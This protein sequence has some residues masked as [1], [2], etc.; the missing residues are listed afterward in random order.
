MHNLWRTNR[1]HLVRKCRAVRRAEKAGCRKRIIHRPRTLK[2]W[3]VLCF[4]TENS[5][6]QFPHACNHSGFSFHMCVWVCIWVC[7][8]FS[9]SFIRVSPILPP[10]DVDANERLFGLWCSK[11]GASKCTV[12]CL[13][14]TTCL[15]WWRWS[16]VRGARC[17]VLWLHLPGTPFHPSH[18]IHLLGACY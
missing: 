13:A 17:R 9:P 2:H 6:Y 18:L 1:K 4:E 8:Y 12:I 10:W 7:V 11:W 16:V 14:F 3:K 15:R 5:N